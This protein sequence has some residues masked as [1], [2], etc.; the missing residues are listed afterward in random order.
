[1][2]DTQHTKATGKAAADSAFPTNTNGDVKAATIR[3]TVRDIYESM[4]LVGTAQYAIL[5]AEPV[6]VATTANGTLSTA[7]ADGET[8]DGITLAEDDR[9]LIKDQSTASENGIYS[10]NESGAPTRVSDFNTTDTVFL[11]SGVYVQEGTSNAKTYWRLTAPT[12]TITIG[13][14]NLTFEQLPNLPDDVTIG[15]DLI[16]T[17]DLTVNGTT[18]TYNST[19]VEVVDPLF[20][21]G[22]DNSGDTLD[23]GAYWQYND[24]TEKFGGVFRDATDDTI[25]FFKGLEAEPTTTVNIGGTGY[26]LSNIK[27]GTVS[28]GTWQGTSI[29]VGYG[30]TGA[31]T[32]S[33]ARSNLGL[34]TIATQA[35]S[36]VSITGGALNGTLGATTPSTIAGTTGSFSGSLSA[37]STTLTSSA[38]GVNDAILRLQQAVGNLTIGD[39][40]GE[41]DFYINDQSTDGTGSIAAIKGVMEVSPTGVIGNKRHGGLAFYTTDDTNSSEK[42]RLGHEGDLILGSPTGGGQGTGTINAEGIYVNGVDVQ[43]ETIIIAVS[44]EISNLTTGT[45]KVTF[46]MPYAM[47]L[48][49]VRASVNTAPTGSVLTVDINESGSTILSTKLTIDAGEKTS[50]TAATAAVISDSALADDAEMTIDIDGVGSTVAGKGLKVTLIG[51]RS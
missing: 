44:D 43:T 16:V 31:S 15:N 39:I 37:L 19:T 28:S 2:A 38:A 6:R 27:V 50:T 5:G 22:K 26:T 21:L 51:T 34:G 13:S 48:T 11:G 41:V 30:G 23:L 36:A 12:G 40:V 47:T 4:S 7:F 14:S 45:A 32:A 10:V 9:I 42:M 17:G 20:K 29:A 1:M 35:A 25:A 3:Q 24:G 33:G 49:A 46:R 18:A 8:I